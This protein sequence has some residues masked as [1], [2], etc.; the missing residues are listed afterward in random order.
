MIRII[1]KSRDEVM[2]RLVCS[3]VLIALYL[4]LAVGSL[5]G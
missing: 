2:A 3:G 1:W 5:T 4:L